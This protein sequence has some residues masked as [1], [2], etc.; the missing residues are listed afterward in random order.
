MR[1]LVLLVMTVAFLTATVF[2][3]DPVKDAEAEVKAETEKSE[4]SAKGEAKKVT[5]KKAEA[6]EK[7]KDLKAKKVEAVDE[8]K[9]KMK[10]TT[11]EAEATVK[12]VKKEVGATEE[13][14]IITTESGLRYQ[15]L[16]LG[17]GKTAEMNMR[18][19]CHYTLWLADSTGLVK[20]SKVDSSHDRDQSF[21][22]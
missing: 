9:K 4:D 15:D 2:A 11:E 7:V 14:E 18:V 20:G 10:A 13:P 8:A 1:N 5:I 22:C 3:G 21:Q 6:D 19:D 17:E 12:M 16:K